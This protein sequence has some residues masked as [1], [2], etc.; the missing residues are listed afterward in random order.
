MLYQLSHIITSNHHKP[1][2]V[3]MYSITVLCIVF[4]HGDGKSTGTNLDYQPMYN[5]VMYIY[6]KG[7]VRMI[8]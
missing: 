3:S 2:D 8:N 1:L 4:L 6:I 7:F 5:I